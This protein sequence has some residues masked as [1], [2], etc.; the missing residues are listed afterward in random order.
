[1]PLVLVIFIV[2]VELLVAGLA[3]AL[4][5][6]VIFLMDLKAQPVAAARP[7][8]LLGGP[9][10]GPGVAPGAVQKKAT[11]P[12]SSRTSTT[13]ITPPAGRHVAR[14]VLTVLVTFSPYCTHSTCC[15][16]RF[17]PARLANEIRRLP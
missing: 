16:P 5:S 12:W 4:D 6:A 10:G 13:R 7:C 11:Q 3:V 1:M 2:A 14:N 15:Q 8:G 9:E 17:W